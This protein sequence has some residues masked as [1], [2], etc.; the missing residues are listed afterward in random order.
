MLG[1]DVDIGYGLRHEECFATFDG[2][3]VALWVG[4][5]TAAFDRNEH[6]ERFALTYR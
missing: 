5:S 3:Y 4:D 2:C 6:T 1:S